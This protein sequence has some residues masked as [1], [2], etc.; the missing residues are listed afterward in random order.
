MLRPPAAGEFVSSSA[1]L[2]Y[3][4][5]ADAPPRAP[6]ADAWVPL[7]ERL[8]FATGLRAHAFE[9]L[10][11]AHGTWRQPASPGGYVPLQ[12]MVRR[13]ADGA[14]QLEPPGAVEFVRGRALTLRRCVFARLGSA[15][16]LAVGG[17]SR[18]VHTRAALS[19][20]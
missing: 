8:L 10:A 15:Y 19:T 12:S 17:A 16:A 1:H 11:F 20:T 2:L 5:L 14:T 13:S 6:P 3:T 9:A 7:H 4:P 18:D